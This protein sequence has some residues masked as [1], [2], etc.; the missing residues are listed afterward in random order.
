MTEPVL[1][2]DALAPEG[3]IIKY[4]GRTLKLPAELP[5]PTAVRQNQKLRE[6][7]TKL[8][9]RADRAT[10]G[11]ELTSDEAVESYAEEEKILSALH[12]G[13]L[14]LLKSGG[15]EP[16]ELE[17]VQFSLGQ[18]DRIFGFALTGDVE[19]ASSDDAVVEA[20]TG[21]ETGDSE[22][23]PTTPNRAERRAAPKKS[24][25]KRPSGSKKHSPARS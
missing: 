7:R 19:M 9:E 16:K 14:D 24:Q 17:G 6:Y 2:L 20:L 25:K 3:K 10:R 18:I 8:I 1:D 23:P 15:T 22:S 13:V 11:E 4:Q 21:G 12:E 5:I